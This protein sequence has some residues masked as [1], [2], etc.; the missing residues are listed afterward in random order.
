MK[1]VYRWNPDTCQLEEITSTPAVEW[2][3]G[4]VRY[5]RETLD[6]MKREHLTPMEDWTNTW[7]AKEKERKQLRGELPESPVMRQERRQSVAEAFE[8]V[9]AGHRPIKRDNSWLKD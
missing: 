7:A 4:G 1:R 9:R 3:H 5:G 6:K 2:L 8:R